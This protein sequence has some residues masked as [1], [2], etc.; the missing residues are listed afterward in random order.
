MCTKLIESVKI[1]KE[2]FYEDFKKLAMDKV[3]NVRISVARVITQQI[4]K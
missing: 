1:F 4:R 3:A 2:Y